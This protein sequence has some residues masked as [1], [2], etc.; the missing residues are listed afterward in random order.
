MKRSWFWVAIWSAG[1]FSA[2]SLQVGQGTHADASNEGAAAR[3]KPLRSFA[4][5][6]AHAHFAEGC[7]AAW[8][9]AGDTGPVLEL[10]QWHQDSPVTVRLAGDQ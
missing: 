9:T 8:S 6:V 1:T 3:R 7:E 10:S 4:D 2:D 5:N